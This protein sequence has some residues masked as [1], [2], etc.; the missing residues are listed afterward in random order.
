VPT[1]ASLCSSRDNSGVAR[2]RRAGKA[3]LRY[4]WHTVSR[5]SR[6]LAVA[7]ATAL[8]ASCSLFTSFD[9]VGDQVPADATSSDTLSSGGE[10]GQGNGEGGDGGGG[11]DGSRDGRADSSDGSTCLGLQCQQVAC[12]DGGTTTVSGTVRDPAKANPVYD[13][14]VYVPNGPVGPMPQGA[15]CDRCGV[16]PSGDPLVVALTASDGTFT[17]TNMPVGT[18]IP[19]VIQVGRWRRQVAIPI[20][21][22]CAANR[23]ANA[24]L[25]RLPKD[26]TEGDIPHIAI[27]TGATDAIE[28]VLRRMGVADMEFTDSTGAGRIHIYQGTGGVTAG[29][30]TQLST[31][32]WSDATLL[33]KYDMVAAA[34]D[35]V[36]PATQPPP[37]AS[38][39]NVADFTAQ[40]GRLLGTHFQYKWVSLGPAPLPSS[41]TFVTA[42]AAPANP[43]SV[44]VETTFPKGEALAEWLVD[45][46]AS[47]TKGT[48]SLAAARADVTATHAPSSAWLTATTPQ[49]VPY[50]SFDS[51]FGAD[52]GAA[53]GKTAIA[54][55]HFETPV[56]G[57]T[58]FPAECA[59]G[60]MTANDLAAEFALFDLSACVQDDTKA[61]QPPPTQ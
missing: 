52:A 53:C 34:C 50:F 20:V 49:I 13:A 3:S 38:L 48:L 43:L 19:L 41:A 57:A 6:A 32:L 28:C 24:D 30:G 54:D 58:L 25:T 35:A 33:A 2:D 44:S 15:S 37:P 17:L 21:S 23:I 10:G 60:P 4:D 18:N 9:G 61:P 8:S 7:V 26:H 29:A 27:A 1:S 36:N 56:A 46:D 55:F 5:T 40:G 14:I 22:A 39:L 12:P 51:P 16:P 31:A 47:T 59:A 11:R 42:G 45:V